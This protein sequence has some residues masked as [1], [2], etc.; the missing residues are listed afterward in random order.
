MAYWSHE[1]GVYLLGLVLIATIG[2]LLFSYPLTLVG[3][4]VLHRCR[5]PGKC[6]VVD[7][8][9]EHDKGGTDNR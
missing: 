7:V 3:A 9:I 8:A 6:Q 5:R 1:A 2:V 4:D